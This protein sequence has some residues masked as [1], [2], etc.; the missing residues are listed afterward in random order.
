M[1][2]RD[3]PSNRYIRFSITQGNE[4]WGNE[5]EVGGT[6]LAWVRAT[7]TAIREE[8]G[9]VAPQSIWFRRYNPVL[10]VP[11]LV[12]IL[13]GFF[14]FIAWLARGL[15]V[16]FHLT[17]LDLRHWMLVWLVVLA[18]TIPSIV[19]WTRGWLLSAWPSIEFDF[20]PD[21][22]KHE[23]IQRRKIKNLMIFLLIPF[24]LSMV[25]ELIGKFFL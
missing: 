24:I 4:P 14:A 10:V 18:V 9:K 5:A 17:R 15:C 11:I 20:G 16:M 1:S 22:L 3:Y 8:I 23:A 12:F 21:H 6:D 7:F 2:A 19:T 25:V 13:G